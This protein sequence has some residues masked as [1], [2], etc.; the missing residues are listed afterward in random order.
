MK[1]GKIDC[2][3]KRNKS[4]NRCKL[5]K[6]TRKPKK[7]TKSKNSKVKKSKSPKSKKGLKL[8]KPVKSDRSD[9]KMMVLT[10]KGIIHFGQVGYED[11]LMH[12]DKNRRKTIAL[13]VKE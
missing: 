8:Y 11:Y 2:R 13:E 7:S 1:G 10:K 9:K 5:L 6:K 3:F 12:K 4:I